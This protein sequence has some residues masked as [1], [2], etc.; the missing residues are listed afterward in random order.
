M[1]S[2]KHLF[3]GLLLIT[4]LFLA[5][6]RGA[7]EQ[8]PVGP[9]GPPGPQGPAGPPGDPASA[10]G[11][12]VGSDRCAACHE[13]VFDVFSKSGHNY[14][15]NPVIDGQPPEYPFSQVSDPPAGL[16]WDDISYVIGGY[17]WKARFVDQ[18]GYII[19]GDAVQYNL[20]NDNLELGDDWVAYHPGEELPYNCGECHTTGY[21]PTGNQDG[22][23][24]MVGT[25]EEPG[26]T[27][28]EC[29][30][31]GGLHV[32]SPYL[33]DMSIDRSAESCGECHRRGAVEEV[34][35]SGGFIRHHEQYEELFQSKH[36]VLDCVTCHDPHTGVVQ[37][38]QADLQT[39]RTTCENCHYQEARYH[40]VDI[41]ANFD[42]IECHMPRVTKSA[43]GDAE[44]FEGD[45]RTHVMAID[46]FLVNQF[47]EDG[48][49]ANS[50]ISLDFACR[51][52]HVN[53][54]GLEK[55]DQSLLNIADGYH[56]KP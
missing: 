22:L 54:T 47:N 21:R 46:P 53:D 33:V 7:P 24:G 32:Q 55:S 14:K 41:H 28:E 2:K 30:G 5:G 17:N 49:V 52:C 13:D 16:T 42:C 36:L 44:S 4:L 34:D 38:R 50:Q 45:L 10:S 6:C 23:P 8:G 35:A 19:T 26:I 1:G 18:Q 3:F 51:H 15:L 27:C 48:T 25:W 9:A 56:D 37:L 29:H 43:V 11:D 40:A 31:A 39:V 12:F 20:E